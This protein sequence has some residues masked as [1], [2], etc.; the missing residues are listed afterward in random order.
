MSHAYRALVRPRHPPRRAGVR[1][2]PF[3]RPQAPMRS[4]RSQG[5]AT[6]LPCSH[7]PELPSAGSVPRPA[8]E[9]GF[10]RLG[11]AVVSRV[12]TVRDPRRANDAGRTDE[13]LCVTRVQVP[14]KT[15]RR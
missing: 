7:K 9:D 15:F 8:A 3:G 4:D 12:N 6:P 13:L 10:L 14:G 11:A 5:T 1:R 2:H